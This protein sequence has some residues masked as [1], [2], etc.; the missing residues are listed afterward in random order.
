MPI[1]VIIVPDDIQ[2]NDPK[3]GEPLETPKT[4]ERKDAAA[5]TL[6]T[7]DD[8]L[9]HLLSHPQWIKSRDMI[10]KATAIEDA[11]ADGKKKVEL[12][13]EDWEYLCTCIDEPETVT[14][15][16]TTKGFPWQPW[17]MRQVL[18][19]LDAVADAKQLKRPKAVPA[20]DEAEEV[21]EE[22][23]KEDVAAE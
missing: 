22:D 10:K 7:W 6:W 23:A 18:P 9:Q 14:V 2:L 15:R 19:F 5:S 11:F 17:V 1:R 21:V 13:E 8:F 20:D 3:T 16:G 12:A 4:P